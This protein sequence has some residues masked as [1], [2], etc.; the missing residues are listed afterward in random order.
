MNNYL[1]TV[2]VECTFIVSCARTVTHSHS[3]NTTPNRFFKRLLEESCAVSPRLFDNF[4]LARGYETL[5]E[6]FTSLCNNSPTTH[7]SG[8]ADRKE[9]KAR[10]RQRE[11]VLKLVDL[12]NDLV[13]CGPR[14]LKLSS[15]RRQQTGDSTGDLASMRIRYDVCSVQ[16]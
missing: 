8:T 16:L 14:E 10:R 15:S 5:V 7:A 2:F 13:Y 4:A 6:Y 12:I 9:D 3:L 11:R 1:F